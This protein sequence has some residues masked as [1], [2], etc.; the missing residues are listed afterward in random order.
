MIALSRLAVVA[1]LAAC[2][3]RSVSPE[4]AVAA[5]PVPDVSGPFGVITA[6]AFAPDGTL[7]LGDSGTGRLHALTPEVVDNPAAESWYNLKNIHGA[8]ASRLGTTKDNVRIR[9]L[10]IHPKNQEAYLAVGRAI[11]DRYASAV[12]V[13]NQAGDLRILDLSDGGSSVAIP[14]GPADGH[15]FY[16]EV[17]ARDLTITDLE[18]HDQTLYA[19]GLSNAD[20]DS[21]LYATPVPFEGEAIK[22]TV[23]IFHGV[24]AQNETRAPIRTMKVVDLGGEPHLVAAYTCTPL[25]TI[26]LSDIDNGAHIVGKTVAELGY[27]NTPGDMMVFPVAEQGQEP[28]DM[29]LLTNKNRGAQLIPVASIA[30]AAEGEGITAPTGLAPVALGAMDI[31]LTSV[32]DADDQN[33]TVIAVVRRDDYTGDVELLSYPKGSYLRLSEYQ[34]EYEMPNYS[35]PESQQGIKQFHNQQKPAEGHAAYVKP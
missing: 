23:E 6:I 8:I 11:D 28:V 20:F 14:G 9:D 21:T 12:V 17:P 1:F 4:P 30:Q 26:P 16:G 10:A 13:A 3:T 18:F 31:P 27:G 22:T 33:A 5:A 24:H 35:Y 7:F 15:V 19:A 34:S 32:I 2:S 29:M 25:V